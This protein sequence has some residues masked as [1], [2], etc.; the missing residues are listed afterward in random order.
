RPTSSIAH[1]ASVALWVSMPIAV[2][3]DALLALS[4]WSAGRTGSSAFSRILAPMRP[5]PDRST[6]KAGALAQ[7]SQSPGARLDCGEPP[8]SP[9]EPSHLRDGEVQSDAQI[10]S[11][12]RRRDSSRYGGLGLFAPRWALSSQPPQYRRSLYPMTDDKTA[13]TSATA[14]SDAEWRAVLTPE[15]YKVL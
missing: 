12:G 3:R 13:S 15:Q 4:R 2:I 11:S 1:A 14:K 9:P 6:K 8:A 10:V 5:R 7:F